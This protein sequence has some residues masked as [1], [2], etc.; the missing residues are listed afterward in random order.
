MGGKNMTVV[1]TNK[2]RGERVLSKGK[3]IGL[4]CGLGG[5]VLYVVLI[6]LFLL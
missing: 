5:G 4:A 3:T 2:T 1:K 6:A